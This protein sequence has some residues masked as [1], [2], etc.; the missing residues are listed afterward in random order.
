M[1]LVHS[2]TASAYGTQ[3]RVVVGKVTGNGTGG[4]IFQAATRLGLGSTG[5]ASSRDDDGDAK[6]SYQDLLQ[7]SGWAPA[8]A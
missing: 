2:D 4:A 1:T 5:K 6:E 3:Y 8:G 7:R